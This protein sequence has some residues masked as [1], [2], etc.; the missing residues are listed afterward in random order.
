[1]GKG[2]LM[3]VELLDGG[4]GIHGFVVALNPVGRCLS[5]AGHLAHVRYHDAPARARG[6]GHARHARAKQSL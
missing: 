3:E 4:V 2:A 6:A 1:M 5:R